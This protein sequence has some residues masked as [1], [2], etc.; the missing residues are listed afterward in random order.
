MSSMEMECSNI[1][2]W[3]PDFSDLTLK[4]LNDMR[5][6]MVV[7][8]QRNL[9]AFVWLIKVMDAFSFLTTEN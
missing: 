5:A 7:W 1:D 3:V 4:I 6:S 8:L 2:I 9:T